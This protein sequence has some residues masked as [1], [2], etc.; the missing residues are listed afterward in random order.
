M[1]PVFMARKIKD[2]FTMTIGF[3]V[4]ICGCLLKINYTFNETMPI[5]QY[6][7]GSI[8]LFSGTLIAEAAAVAIMSKVLSP[9]LRNGFFNAGLLSGL[10]DPTGRAIGN[11][12]FTLFSAIS[13]KES[14]PF[15]IYVIGSAVIT[16]LMILTIALY[17][18]LEKHIVVRAIDRDTPSNKEMAKGHLVK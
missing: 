15:Y 14:F 12:S 6:F 11:A 2:K 5:V 9:K 7:E 4:I 3:L 8:I 1:A 17:P 16:I 10:A 18:L 13:G